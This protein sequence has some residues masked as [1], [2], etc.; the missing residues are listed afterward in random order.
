MALLAVKGVNEDGK[1][2]LDEQ[3]PGIEHADV[4]VAFLTDEE[5]V[6]VEARR[7]AG[8]RLLADMRKGVNF[9]GEK[10]NREELYEERLREL[11]ERRRPG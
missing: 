6:D 2:V 7:A 8:E 3:P 5:V 4:V 11:E 9:G 10:F 1:I